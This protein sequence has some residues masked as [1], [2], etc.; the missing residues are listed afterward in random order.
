[1]EFLRGTGPAGPKRRYSRS[2]LFSSLVEAFPAS[3][4]PSTIDTITDTIEAKILDLQQS[5]IS[6]DRIAAIV[7]TTLKHFNTPAF[8]RYLT[9][10]TDLASSAQ[11]KREMKKY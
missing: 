10:H 9:S 4:R 6:S 3:A 7:L 11:L 2:Q 1:M 5:E 8:V